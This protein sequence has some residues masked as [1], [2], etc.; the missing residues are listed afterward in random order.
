LFAA[1]AA[2][3]LSSIWSVSINWWVC[4]SAWKNKHKPVGQPERTNRNLWVN[5]KEQTETC[6]SAWKNKQKPYSLFSLCNDQE[7]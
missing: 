2:A 7:G 1:T 3:C 6:G 4:G 5:L